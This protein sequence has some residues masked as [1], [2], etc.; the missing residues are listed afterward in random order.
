MATITNEVSLDVAEL[1][2]IDA[3]V[4][5]Q[6]DKQ[7]RYLKV[8]ITNHGEKI[9]IASGSTVVINARRSNNTADSFSG[10]VNDDGTVTVPITYY[11]LEYD[12]PVECDISIINSGDV[13]LTTT[14]F[15][16]NVER[17]ARSNTSV[18]TDPN[19]SLLLELIDDVEEVT[20]EYEESVTA[21]MGTVDDKMEAVDA[22]MAQ[23]AEDVQAA[24][25]ATQLVTGPFYI[26]DTAHSKTYQA[27][28]QIR[29]GK[30]CIIYDEYTPST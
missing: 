1:N 29:N 16:L 13:M 4:G 11:M 27:A 17:A 14:L 18:D 3:I 21:L 22:T 30:P 26:V 24:I 20:A 2:R 5:K 28:I 19:K 7:S 12:G 10:T 6:Y 23:V 15:Q 25:D 9:M 8:T